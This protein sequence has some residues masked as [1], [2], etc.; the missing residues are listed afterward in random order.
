MPRERTS[1]VRLGLIGLG[2]IGGTVAELAAR[3]P[4]RVQIVG[5]LVSAGGKPRAATAPRCVTR[6]ADLLA[7]SPEVVIE[8]A[9][10]PALREHGAAVLAA[11]VDLVP[12]SVGLFADDVALEI[13]RDAARSGASRIRLS[14][15]AVAGVDGLLGARALGLD[16]VRY[17]FVMSPSA[18]GH[19]TG[20][21]A[22]A[23]DTACERVM[24]R[25]SA[26]EAAL[27]FP[28]HANVTATIALAGVGF[29][30][31]EVELVVDTTATDNR[32]EIHAS[33]FFG[34]LSVVVQG[35]RISQSSPSSRLVA[36][37]LFSA[38]LAAGGPSID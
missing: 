18:W 22:L 13:F 19:G 2:S 32:H 20:Q 26:R 14:S 17:R 4:G 28:R 34:K 23:G 24:F 3:L 30:R 12:S 25:G 5:A 21:G 10:Q 37:S 33:G 36:G 16:S 7:L 31:T 11:G 1:P 8:C 27:Q 38:A 6:L 29:E 15:G 35:K 9:G